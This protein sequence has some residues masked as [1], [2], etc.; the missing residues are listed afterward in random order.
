MFRAESPKV[1]PGGLLMW[2]FDNR[3]WMVLAVIYERKDLFRVNGNRA[4]GGAVDKAREGAKDHA[5]T[6]YWAVYDQKKKVLESGFGPGERLVARETADRL[7]RDFTTNMTV[8][9][10][11]GVLEKGESK[12]AAKP[13]AWSGYPKPPAEES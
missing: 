4:K 9:Q 2:P 7:K 6:I 12:S 1:L 5:R 3:D 11:L 10:I 8:I 13:L